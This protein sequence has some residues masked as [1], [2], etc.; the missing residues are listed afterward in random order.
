[1][2]TSNIIIDYL[3]SNPT[4]SLKKKKNQ[5]T[6]FFLVKF[7]CGEAQQTHSHVDSPQLKLDLEND[8]I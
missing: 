6:L 4:L 1:M 3:K 2:F 8:S 5:I 7:D